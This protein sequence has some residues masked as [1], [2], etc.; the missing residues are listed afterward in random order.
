MGENASESIETNVIKTREQIA[1]EKKQ[2]QRNKIACIP[3]LKY[4]LKIYTKITDHSA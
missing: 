4:Y 3:H 2:I 1:N